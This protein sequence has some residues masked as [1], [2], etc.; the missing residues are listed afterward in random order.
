MLVQWFDFM[1]CVFDFEFVFIGFEIG[2]EVVWVIFLLGCLVIFN[3]F[4]FDGF[5]EMQMF[6]GDFCKQLL[7]ML[8]E[9]WYYVLI[10][11]DEV[12]FF[13]FQYDKVVFKKLLID[14]VCCGCKCGMCLVVVM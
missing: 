12:Q 9:I 2:V 3:L 10:V 8:L 6:V 11:F 14:L 5:E 4:E 13:V 7:W 1:V